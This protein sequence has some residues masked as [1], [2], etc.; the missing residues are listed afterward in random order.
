MR[1]TDDR[2]HHMPWQR[3]QRRSH[4]GG[5]GSDADT[6]AMAAT[7]RHGGD[8]VTAANPATA[9]MAAT[10]RH[11]GGGGSDADTAVMAATQPWRRRRQ[12][13]RHGGDTVTTAMQPRR[14]WQR[15]QGE[16]K[17]S[18]IYFFLSRSYNSI[19]ILICMLPNF[20]DKTCGYE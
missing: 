20:C 19:I 1:T 7:Q 18:F 16:F 8:T 2:H 17:L 5:E 6:A 9:A 14:R 4:G 3:W 10:Q 11:G 12:R 15:R 13:C